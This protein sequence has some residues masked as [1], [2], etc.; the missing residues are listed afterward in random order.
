MSRDVSMKTPPIYLHHTNFIPCTL[1]TIAIFTSLKITSRSYTPLI[2]LKFKVIN[3][4]S[5][6][7][8]TKCVKLP[9]TLTQTADLP[10]TGRVSNV[11]STYPF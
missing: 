10:E 1:S 4:P 2:N 6:Q 3:F 8:T 9:I 11:L 7:G 5:D